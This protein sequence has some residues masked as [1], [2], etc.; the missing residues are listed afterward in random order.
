MTE[1]NIDSKIVKVNQETIQ[2]QLQQLTTINPKIFQTMK[3]NQ[4]ITIS[5]LN[6]K[7]FKVLLFFTSSLGCIFCQGTL[8]DILGL[9]DQL[10]LM[11]TIPVI[12][13][14]EDNETYEKFINT[15][16]KTKEFGQLHHLERNGI[17]KHFKLE[18]MDIT[19]VNVIYSIGNGLVELFRL[20]KLGYFLDKSYFTKGLK[21]ISQPI[22]N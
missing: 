7:G 22:R 18:Q 19:L 6:E 15:N 21:I 4:G 1:N 13:H 16:E 10:L 3:T 8:D 14:D 17:V 2:E 12:V 5:E 11:N 20:K 9:K